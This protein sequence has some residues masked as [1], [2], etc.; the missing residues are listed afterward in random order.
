MEERNAAIAL[1]RDQEDVSGVIF[2]VVAQH[3][4]P[5]PEIKPAEALRYALNV[6]KV[7]G[8]RDLIAPEDEREMSPNDV[9]IPKVMEVPKPLDE[10]FIL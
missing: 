6:T 10:L 5:A 1:I 3:R 7:F 8:F 2:S 4:V 9:S